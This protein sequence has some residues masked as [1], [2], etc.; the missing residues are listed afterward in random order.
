MASADGFGSSN[1]LI[2]NEPKR[3]LFAVNAGSNTVSSFRVGRKHLTL[4]SVVDSQGVFPVSL[5][6]HND[7]FYVL[8]SGSTGSL[9]GFRVQDNCS[10]FPLSDSRA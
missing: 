4:V 6:E 9:V 8:N 5:T 2:L 7:V 3:C 1:S 10:L